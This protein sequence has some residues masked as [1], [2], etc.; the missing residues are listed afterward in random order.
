[1]PHRGTPWW[2]S[3][4][5]SDWDRLEE[6]VRRDIRVRD[7][8]VQ[9]PFPRLVSTS[10]R[11]IAAAVEGYKREAAVVDPRLAHEVTC[12]FKATAL[13]DLCDQLRTE[14]GIQLSAGP[15]V[16]DDKVTLLC[17]RLPLREV[18]RQLSRPFGY[19]WLR[20]KKDSEYRYELVQDL[21]SQLLEEELRNRDRNEALIALDHE[22]SR[23]QKYLG[24]SPDEALARSK[25]APPEEKALLEHLATDGWGLVQIWFRL[26]P[27]QLTA[28]RAGAEL[29]F[30][31]EPEEN[32][33][34][35]P[36]DLARGIL[37]SER[38]RRI[39]VSDGKYR[40]GDAEANPDGKLPRAIPEARAMLMLR[41]PQSELGQ[42][43]LTGGSGVFIAAES[44][45]PGTFSI[46]G[47]AG[48]L[49]IG[50]SPSVLN[51]DN[52]AAHARMARDPV[53]RARVTVTPVP[54]ARFSVPDRDLAGARPAA[55]AEKKVTT[56]EVLEAIHQATGLPIVA[57]FYTHL[58]P[59]SVVTVRNQPVLEVLNQL[60]DTM[61]MRWNKE[62]AWLQFR[63]TGFFND[64]LKEV[65]NRLLE[66]WSTARRQ[67]GILA[68]DELIEIAGLSDAQLDA[69]DMAE[70][71][72]EIWGLTEWELLSRRPYL[73]P[74]LRFLAG[75]TPAQRQEAMS[76]AGL[77]FKKLTLAQ[78]QQ[79]LSY[80]LLPGKDW[81]DA[82]ND[83][84]GA[85]L[86]VDYTQPGW[87]EWA[88]PGWGALVPSPVREHTREAA[89]QAALRIDPRA[90]EAQ[91]RPTIMDLIFVYQHA[92]RARY[93][94]VVRTHNDGWVDR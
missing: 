68:L 11:Q 24:L 6:T 40:L 45:T 39:F 15:S 31:Q 16:A 23:F 48:S 33:Q 64:R 85:A 13:S 22:M 87:F 1:M 90:T 7:D 67:R 94:R 72:R 84:S 61:H 79:F 74:H 75:F 69:V 77:P 12:A 47:S 32:Q 83:L 93:V 70:G 4:R 10:E 60:A 26:S 27:Q 44:R 38:D 9:I 88:Q 66:R 58:Y 17:A 71:A 89:L 21:R 8:F 91:I 50:R 81:S 92:P 14:T 63:S 25:T 43:T 36:S 49:A 59:A 52:A 82:D 20:S 62:G 46:T 5:A 41:M 35:L 18:M 28:L 54:G 76:P 86:Q 53:L 34:P 56:A 3:L 80:A 65:P 55:S 37:E 29:K 19:I 78:Q 42:F 57:D 51:P 73:R 2:S 30:S